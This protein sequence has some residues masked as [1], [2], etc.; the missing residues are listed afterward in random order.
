MCNLQSMKTLSSHTSSAAPLAGGPPLVVNADGWIET[1]TRADSPNY[2]IRPDVNDISLLVIHNISLPPGEFGTGCVQQFFCNQLDHGAH[3]F[4]REIEGVRVSAHF[5]IDRQG[6]L[7][8]FVATTG[9]AWHAGQS[10]FEGRTTCNDYSIGIELE[11]TDDR[12]YTD[13]QYQTLQALT[14]ALRQRHPLIRPERITGH[15]DI[16]PGRKTDPG[17]AFDWKR[18]KSGVCLG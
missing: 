12:P 3:P 18:Y 2:D 13:G 1:A 7:T 9:R 5:F 8:Q 6:Q 15:S 14:Q 4:F 10:C 16:A 11:G 17:P